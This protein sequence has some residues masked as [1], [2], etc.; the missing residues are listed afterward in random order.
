ML[1]TPGKVSR[2]TYGKDIDLSFQDGMIMF[3]L[4][5]ALQTASQGVSGDIT[6]AA[7]V[8]TIK[9]MKETELPGGGGMK[10]RCNGK[11]ASPDQQAVCVAGGLSTTLDDK[12]Q[13]AEYQVLS[14]TL[15]PD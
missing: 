12:G 1:R 7:L 14:T 2:R 8:S 10:F 15:I 3:T 11:A 5:S 4:V 9:G 13:P 6:L